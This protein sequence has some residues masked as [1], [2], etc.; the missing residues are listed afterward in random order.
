MKNVHF[1]GLFSFLVLGLFLSG[2]FTGDL[3]EI[4]IIASPE[5]I[6]KD[7][8]IYA[9][10]DIMMGRY[11]GKRMARRGVDSPFKFIKDELKKADIVFGNLES[12]I[13]VMAIDKMGAE[14]KPYYD[15]DYNFLAV[16][17]S[18]KALR[19]A[20]FTVVSL[21]NNH[22]KDYGP[23]GITST[24]K[25]LKE[26]GV[27][28]FGAGKNL[29]EAREP[30]II[31]KKGTKFAFLGYGIAHTKDV[32]ATGNKAGIVPFYR[33]HLKADI[34]S[35]KL[36]ADVVIVSIHW[37]VEYD[38][39]PIKR[40]VKLAHDIIDYGADILLGHHPHVVQS[41]EFYKDKPIIYSMG[42]FLFD[43]KA[44]RTSG[45]M[46][47]SFDFSGGK[48]K[49]VGALPL[50]R[51]DAY[52]P[53]LAVGEVKTSQLKELREISKYLNEDK[54][55]LDFLNHDDTSVAMK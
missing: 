20:G 2:Y 42:N 4:K 18:A 36:L 3:E 26:A 47:F 53:K 31:E 55:V 16:P 13:G 9:A 15:K 21:A 8:T 5:I 10:G 17:Q 45:G 49:A 25:Y 40:Q 6:E 24:R 14:E 44:G 52:Y 50:G 46:I 7:I 48:L 27:K 22:A 32:Y 41:I 11:I 1:I 38:V 23:D 19:D 54:T 12:M 30:V 35:A 37:G 43:Q 39:Q 28:F 34:K 29:V 33:K 51:V